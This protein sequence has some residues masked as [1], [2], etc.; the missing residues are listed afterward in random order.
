MK[1]IK[2]IKV[3][4]IKQKIISKKRL[5]SIIKKQDKIKKKIKNKKS[6]L[7]NVKGYKRENNI[8]KIKKLYTKSDYEY[9]GNSF[10]SWLNKY[11]TIKERRYIKENLLK[12]YSLSELGKIIVKISKKKDFKSNISYFFYN[13]TNKLDYNDRFTNVKNISVILNQ[14]KDYSVNKKDFENFTKNMINDIED[15]TYDLY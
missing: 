6:K 9:I 4:K 1:R 12:H 8:K 11:M 3:K 5:K 13:T 15:L 2:K 10:K 7:V 14:I